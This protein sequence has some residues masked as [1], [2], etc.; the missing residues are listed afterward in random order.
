MSDG[1]ADMWAAALEYAFRA[2]C[3]P[4][5]PTNRKDTGGSCSPSEAA[6]EWRFL[7]ATKGAWAESRALICG[8]NGVDPEI[9]R[10]EALRRG[11]SRQAKYGL[12]TGE[13]RAGMLREMSDRDQRMMTDYAAGIALHVIAKTY[14]ISDRRIKQIAADHGVKRRRQHVHLTPAQIEARNVPM[15]AEYQA[16]VSMEELTARYGLAESTITSIAH[17]RGVKR[18]EGYIAAIGRASAIAAAED[19]GR[20]ARNAEIM[21]RRK[22]GESLKEIA[23]DLGMKVDTARSVVNRAEKRAASNASGEVLGGA[24]VAGGG[25]GQSVPPF[26]EQSMA[27]GAR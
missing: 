22:A 1:C 9:V 18:P 7:T 19:A 4:L 21:R 20:T 10:A 25:G 8:I 2:A 23:R 3:E 26:H 14:R 27:G 16:G 5:C 24:C 15:L 6:D 12:L 11:I 17:R 13:M